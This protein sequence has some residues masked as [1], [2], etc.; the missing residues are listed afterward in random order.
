M[1]ANLQHQQSYDSTAS[2]TSPDDSQ[3]DYNWMSTKEVKTHKQA[4]S[5]SGSHR[6]ITAI[7]LAPVSYQTVF[8]QLDR[9]GRNLSTTETHISLK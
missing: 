1:M 5:S 3:S 6:T 4:S 9:E 2:A 8:N 7:S